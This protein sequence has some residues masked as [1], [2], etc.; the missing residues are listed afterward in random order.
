[1]QRK[2]VAPM[3]VLYA[4]QEL[5]IPEVGRYAERYGPEIMAEAGKFGLQVAGPWVFVSY[6]LPQNGQ[7]R[8]RTEFCLP[9]TNADA[10]SG[11]RF[12]IK[13]L[14]SFSCASAEYRGELHQLF[15]NGYQPL[16]REI[17]AANLRFTGESRE[18]YHAW[19]GPDSPGNRIEIQFGVL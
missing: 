9:V 5:T 18:V 13:S 7:E 16:V 3:T 14:D 8:Y 1:M 12:A 19:H 4:A 2:T 17:A 11:G 10:Y 6:Q 15:A